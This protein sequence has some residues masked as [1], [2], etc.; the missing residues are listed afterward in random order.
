MYMS[1]TYDT[2]TCTVTT[3][4]HDRY[5]IFEQSYSLI[6]TFYANNVSTFKYPYSFFWLP[7][8]QQPVT[9]NQRVV[10]HGQQQYV[11]TYSMHKTTPANVYT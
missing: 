3:Y 11:V 5:A 7:M 1:R 9:V 2:D 10:T 8:G 4:L 6:E